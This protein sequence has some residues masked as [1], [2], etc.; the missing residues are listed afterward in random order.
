MKIKMIVA[1]DNEYGI[2][3]DGKMAWHYPEDFKYFKEYTKNSICIM[4]SNTYKDILHHKKSDEGDFLPDRFS[5]VF[6]T[7]TKNYRNNNKHD[8]IAFVDDSASIF[9]DLL[10]FLSREDKT[11]IKGYDEINI[12]GGKSVYQ[13]FLDC[14]VISEISV[15]HI[16]RSH[17]CDL[18]FNELKDVLKDYTNIDTEELSNNCIVKKYK[19]TKN[20][21]TE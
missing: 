10:Y 18:Y 16:N 13:T 4:G 8:N 6:T 7:K 5:I 1:I 3:K 14:G 15:T 9:T 21:E 11:L 17:D 19:R 2:G 20:Y 12:I